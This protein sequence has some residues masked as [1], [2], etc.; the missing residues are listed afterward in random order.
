[1]TRTLEPKH[2]TRQQIQAL[3]RRL[4]S[5]DV[6]AEFGMP[7]GVDVVKTMLRMADDDM[8]FGA[9]SYGLAFFPDEYDAWVA[10]LHAEGIIAAGSMMPCPTRKY[11]QK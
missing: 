9:M 11:L 10:R 4:R 5:V 7:E 8:L 1:M 3:A 2:A 6:Q